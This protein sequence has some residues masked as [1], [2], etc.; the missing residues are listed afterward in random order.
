MMGGIRHQEVHRTTGGYIAHIMKGA[1]LAF[2]TRGELSAA[3][4]G[5]LLMVAV[6]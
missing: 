3:R 4:T 6:I 5:R 1:L 2:V